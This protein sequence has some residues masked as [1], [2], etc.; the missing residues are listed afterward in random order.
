[1]ATLEGALDVHVLD[2]R[3]HGWRETGNVVVRVPGPKS[4]GAIRLVLESVIF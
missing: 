4:T 2:T 3:S 1:M